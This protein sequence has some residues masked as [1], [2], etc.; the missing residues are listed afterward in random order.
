MPSVSFASIRRVRCSDT[1]TVIED[2][3][4]ASAISGLVSPSKNRSVKISAERAGSSDNACRRS[5]RRSP[6]SGREP[7]AAGSR[8]RS[9][10][11]GSTPGT[12]QIECRVDRRPAQIVFGMLDGLGRFVPASFL[13]TILKKDGLQD[14]FGVGG[15]AGDPVGRPEH[16]GM[17]LAVHHIQRIGDNRNGILVFCCYE[18][19]TSIAFL[20]AKT[21]GG[22]VYYGAC[23]TISRGSTTKTTR[24]GSSPALLSLPMGLGWFQPSPLGERVNVFY[25]KGPALLKLKRVDIH[26]F[27]S[28]YDRTEMKFHGSGI[29]AIV[30]PN[31]CGKSNISDAISWVLGEQSA[32]SLRGS[33]MQDVIFAGTRERKPLGMSQV[34][35]SMVDPL[36][37]H[38]VAGAHEIHA[39]G[40]ANGNGHAHPEEITITR[41]LYRSG[42]SEYLINGKTAR[43]RDIQDLFSGT[44]LGPESYAIIEQG[45]IGQILSNKPADRRAIIEEAAGIGKYKT[46][47]RLAEAKLESA[48]QNLSRVFDILEEVGRQVNSLKRQASKARRY[49]ELRTEMVTFLR[50]AVAG[51]FRMLEGDAARMALDLSQA[52]GLFTE[53]SGQLQEKEGEHTRL[54]ETCY[55]TEA[56]LTAARARVAELNLES[57][58]TRGPAGAA[59]QADRRDRRAAR[60]ER[61]GNAGSGDAPATAA[62]RVGRSRRKLSRGW[63]RKARLCASACRRKPPSATLS[64]TICGS[65]NG[66]SNR[67]AC[68]CCNCWAKSRRCAIKWSRSTNTWPRS[69]AIPRAPAKKKRS[70][71]AIWLAWTR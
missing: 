45:R 23:T 61:N 34:T 65:A 42:E 24:F 41:R 25:R 40:H 1:A 66:D 19:F 22:A 49:E 70:R 16:H 52:Q 50:Q 21:G 57:E 44:G 63:K 51:R 9:T 53:I 33:H 54:Q 4:S 7:P 20:P 12:D 35:L 36:G 39:N 47:K 6:S 11:A 27:K 43:L 28:F 59:S 48:K 62:G 13:R 58:R 5:S 15:V 71:R 67:P 46:R 3:P 18:R 2:I 10:P 8:S 56:E 68:A 32:K 55:R 38:L 31:G 64:R 26:G 60:R 69:S 17:V 30:G 29:T 37:Q 14:I